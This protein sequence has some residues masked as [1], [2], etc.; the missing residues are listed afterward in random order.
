MALL[1][2]QARRHMIHE[3]FV[4]ETDKNGQILALD[5]GCL[6]ISFLFVCLFAKHGRLVD[7]NM[8]IPVNNYGH[9]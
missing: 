4:I 5:F 7:V 6:E 3:V 2:S 1:L 9:G 8:F